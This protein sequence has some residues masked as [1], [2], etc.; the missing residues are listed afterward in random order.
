[1][2]KITSGR[3]PY[4]HEIIDSEIPTDNPLKLV[5]FGKGM[6]LE[7]QQPVFE[8]VRQ[9]EDSVTLKV[10]AEI[11]VK[12]KTIKEFGE[13]L[14]TDT[15]LPEKTLYLTQDENDGY[16]YIEIDAL[17]LDSDEMEDING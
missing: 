9:T 14:P 5:W 10:S 16:Y 11:A 4:I 7:L 17:K 8:V 15:D 12:V 3:I 6:V 13:I 1:M 2:A